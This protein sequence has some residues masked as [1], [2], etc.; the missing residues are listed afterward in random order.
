MPSP[1]VCSFVLLCFGFSQHFLYLLFGAVVGPASPIGCVPEDGADFFEREFT[2]YAETEYLFVGFFQPVKALVNGESG[3]F[4]K[5]QLFDVGWRGKR[6]RQ[7]LFQRDCPMILTA[8]GIIAVPRDREQPRA[9]LL[10]F[11][12]P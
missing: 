6:F 8:I 4:I 10:L 11:L 12:L 5:K 1:G 3:V 7:G 2:E 9:E